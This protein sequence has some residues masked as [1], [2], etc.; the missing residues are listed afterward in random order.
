MLKQLDTLSPQITLFY[1]GFDRHSSSISG[2]LSILTYSTI[3]ILGIIFS[4][5]FLLK[6]NPRAYFYNRFIYD[7]GIF[8]FNNS[9]LFH[10]ILGGEINNISYD[11]RAFNVIGVNKATSFTNEKR[12][13]TLYDHWIYEPCNN[14]HIGNL[15]DYLNDYKNSFYNGLCINK[16]YNKT[17]KEI[18]NVYDKNFKYPLIEHGNSNPNVTS[19]G[20]FILKCQNYSELNKT[21]CYDEEISDKKIIEVSPIS[22][23]FIDH[24]FDVTNFHYPLVSFYNKIRNTIVL[25]S[26]TINHLNFKPLKLNT[27]SGI[28]INSKSELNSF[29]YDLNEKLTIE[30]ENLGIYGGFI[31]WMGNEMGIYDRTYENIQD[32]SASISGISKLLSI[33]SYYLNYLIAKYTLINDLSN[34]IFKKNEKFYKTTSMKR[35]KSFTKSNYSSVIDN[36]LFFQ[37]TKQKTSLKNKKQNEKLNSI[38]PLY[39]NIID[40]NISKTNVKESSII[41]KNMSYKKISIKQILYFYLCCS[42]NNNINQIE[43]IRKKVLSEEKLFTFYYILGSLSDNVDKYQNI[44]KESKS[45]I[46]KKN[47]YTSQN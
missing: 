14:F 26:C 41:Q 47:V 38:S 8:S 43:I 39:N 37:I 46:R 2:I 32:I 4:L 29:V 45:D 16:F 12:N 6:R 36:E 3:I 1:K 9:G 30:K 28:I 15:K 31:F 10:F 11:D 42:K 17:T 5:D 35:L 40:D 44:N 20:I 34:D 22:I 27:H 23:T 33:I 21:N 18:I 13:I 25:S 7:V 24:Y 19:Y